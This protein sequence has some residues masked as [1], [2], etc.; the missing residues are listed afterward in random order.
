MEPTKK[1]FAN[2]MKTTSLFQNTFLLYNIK[3]H[4][5]V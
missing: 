4:L 5:E 3:D 1:N 2:N